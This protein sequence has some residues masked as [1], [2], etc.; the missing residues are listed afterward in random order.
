MA[1]MACNDFLINGKPN[2]HRLSSS[3][4]AVSLDLA[5][6]IGSNSLH[7]AAVMAAAT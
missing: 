6:A 4:V 5:N 7:N 1:E 2:Q 3:P